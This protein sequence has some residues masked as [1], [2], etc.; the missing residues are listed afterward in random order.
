MK[1]IDYRIDDFTI[2]C[3][4]KG[5]TKKTMG[6]YESILRLFVRYLFDE[7]S[8]VN[9]SEVNKSIVR[10]YIKY[11]QERGKY[12]TVSKKKTRIINNPEGRN[13]YREYLSS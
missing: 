3:Q 8:V 1:K 12:T 6:S 11:T 7:H 13:D 5:L 2:Y 9:A 10:Q 4:S